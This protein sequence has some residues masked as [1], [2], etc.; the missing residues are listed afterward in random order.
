MNYNDLLNKPKH[1]EVGDSNPESITS[2]FLSDKVKDLKSLSQLISQLGNEPL[3]PVACMIA[4]FVGIKVY[5]K[6]SP[7]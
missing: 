7:S 3:L 2:Q 5:E 1:G 4:L 6:V